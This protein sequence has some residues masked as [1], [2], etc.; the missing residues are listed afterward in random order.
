MR[1][2]VLVSPDVTLQR[3]VARALDGST[4]ALVAAPNLV[5]ALRVLDTEEVAG[6]LADLDA[7]SD[8][9]HDVLRL[10]DQAAPCPVY[11]LATDETMTVAYEMTANGV[12]DVARLPLESGELR[13]RLREV[14]GRTKVAGGSSKRPVPQRKSDVLL[15]NSTVVQG[16]R[17]RIGMVARTDLPVAIYGESG[18][19]KEL[20]ARMIHC[21]S[22]RRHGPFVVTNCTALPEALFEND[23]FGH[24]R[25]SYTGAHSR[26]G[27]LLDEAHGGTLVFDEIGDLSLS[28][29]AKLLRLIQ[30]RTYRRVGGTKTLEAD[31]RIIVST[32]VDLVKAV[33]EG[34][35]RSDLY[36]RINVLEITMSALRDHLD[37]LPILVHHFASAFSRKYGREQVT[38]AQDALDRMMRHSWAGNVRE[39]ESVVQSAIALCPNSTITAKDLELVQMVT[40]RGSDPS[41]TGP[42]AGRAM[43]DYD[44]EIPF[45]ESR[46]RHIDAFERGYLT[47]LLARCGG[48]VAAAARAADYD[49]KSFWRLL[50]KHE[51]DVDDIRRGK[52]PRIGGNNG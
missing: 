18:T 37:D 35:F 36:Y 40:H 17:D 20:G 50:Q 51:I 26:T 48:N 1:R 38:F 47:E 14:L 29:Q 15:G 6:V 22:P 13:H 19:G 39:L 28:L 23:L 49:R 30:F 42:S 44:F 4:V 11:V 7:L 25:G 34:R 5:N 2:L 41:G 32:N 8:P 27:G 16:I 3:E 12:R 45:A 21:E 10:V 9:E 31:V 43:P 46:K 24:E 52:I 33:S